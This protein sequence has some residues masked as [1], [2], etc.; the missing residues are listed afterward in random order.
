VT[1]QERLLDL[2]RKGPVSPLKSWIEVGIY[3]PADVVEKM[4][5]RGFEIETRIK[6]YT[7]RRGY[8]VKFAEYIL[9]SE[10]KKRN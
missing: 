10:P 3:R 7:T 1:Q 8:K 9:V 2:L 6:P 5:K 4:R